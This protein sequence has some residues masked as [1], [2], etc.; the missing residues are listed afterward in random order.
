MTK[1]KLWRDNHITFNVPEELR[2]RV[3]ERLK[4]DGRK[5]SDMLIEAMNEYA[6]GGA[7][8]KILMDFIREQSEI[9]QKLYA[10]CRRLDARIYFLQKALKAGATGA[11]IPEDDPVNKQTAP[12]IAGVELE[13]GVSALD[14]LEQEELELQKALQRRP[15]GRPRKYPPKPKYGRPGRPR[16]N[17]TL[18]DVAELKLA[19][20][21]PNIDKKPETQEPK[22]AG[23]PRLEFTGGEN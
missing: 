19:D 18:T 9:N 15:R 7:M 6:K 10:T 3:D 4:A 20:V 17:L 13:A 5:L 12:N 11:E 14:K 16:K 23:E 2:S 21:E 22:E 1:Q 8:L